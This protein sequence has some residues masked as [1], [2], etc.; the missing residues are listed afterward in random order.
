MGGAEGPGAEA[1]WRPAGDGS[2]RSWVGG[3]RELG[4]NRTHPRPDFR[5]VI[6]EMGPRRQAS[7][8]LM[9]KP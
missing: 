1:C 6:C 2:A 7:L 9:R 3:L 8:E 4:A 5:A